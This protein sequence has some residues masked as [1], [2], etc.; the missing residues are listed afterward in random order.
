MGWAV[1]DLNKAQGGDHYDIGNKRL[2]NYELITMHP[3]KSIQYRWEQAHLQLEAAFELQGVV[4]THLCSEWP[5]FFNTMRG[6][7]AAQKNHTLNLASMVGYLAGKFNFR[8]EHI[9]LWT[10]MQWKGTAPKSVTRNQFIH[11]FG[12][13]AKRIAKTAS[14]DVI[15]AI[16]IARYW[17]TIYDRKRF[18]WQNNPTQGESMSPK[19]GY[20]R[21]LAH[22][23]T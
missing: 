11:Y 8:N 14:D 18:Y 10:P 13:D 23:K 22:G 3:T 16:M 20:V 7:I 1:V 17:L 6:K 12:E 21:N 2:W 15:D 4:P 5:M 9:V 19:K